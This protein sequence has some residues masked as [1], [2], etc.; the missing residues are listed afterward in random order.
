MRY[1]FLL[2]FLFACSPNIFAQDST[3]L[4]MEN[5][6]LEQLLNMKVTIASGKEQKLS[7]APG[8]VTV[9]NADEI[10]YSGARDLLD[11]LRGVP[12][13]TFAQDNENILSFGLRGL[14][15]QEGKVLLLRDGFE[16]HEAGYS[17]LQFLQH[18]PLHQLD[19]IEIIRGP[20]SVIYGGNAGLCVI[21]LITMKDKEHDGVVAG[22]LYSRLERADGQK[23]AWFNAGKNFASG[24]GFRVSG[25]FMDGIF[26][27][28]IAELVLDSST[29]NRVDM[30]DWSKTSTA[31]LNASFWFKDLELS[32][33]FDDNRH[34]VIHDTYRFRHLTHAISIKKKF[35]IGEKFS[36]TPQIW[37]KQ[38]YPWQAIN[39]FDSLRFYNAFYKRTEGN[40]VMRYVH[41]EQWNLLAG[42]RFM[43][44]RGEYIEEDSPYLFLISK[45]RDIRFTT[46]SSFLQSE[47]RFGL[48]LLTTGL[49]YEKHSQFGAVLV[50]RINLTGSIT[51]WD[52]D[53]QYNEAFRAPSLVN[54]DINPSI[55]PERTI[56]YE[57]ELG[58]R[59]GEKMRFSLV[60]F[61]MK[62][63]NP[64]IYTSKDFFESYFN[65]AKVQTYGAEAGW[66]FRDKSHEL[67]VS[68]SSYFSSFDA[69]VYSVEE[70]P[71][72]KIAM[73][74]HKVSLSG[75][76]FFGKHFFMSTQTQFFSNVFGYNSQD[77][78]VE[79]R[80]MTLITLA[81]GFRN[82]GEHWD[83]CFSVQDLLNERYTY[84]QAYRSGED[85]LQGAGRTLN[86]RVT[87]RLPLR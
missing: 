10:R 83:I 53:L 74:Q 63:I 45:Q 42:G 33:L 3:R 15:A 87:Y 1:L 69:P 52:F 75:R 8:M 32:Y 49:R 61:S 59:V 72:A 37:Q 7:D 46:W 55:K 22:A 47:N 9:I 35:N 80:P 21:N 13:I 85:P 5:M 36:F 65:E 78:L 12:G 71:R 67:N 73:P 11:L 54:M 4:A 2:F 76:K 25:Q 20:G 27:D 28:R 77:E 18:Y 6:S 56:D 24:F 86:M 64:I 40:L 60:L 17:T 62:V 44:D 50:P 79:Q 82:I 16:L 29:V 48:F 19:R 58:R 26:S 70:K 14:W 68:Y 43:E 39:A 57:L 34:D 66:L 84:F 31:S 30:K 81:G 51:A 41:S 23:T 38:M